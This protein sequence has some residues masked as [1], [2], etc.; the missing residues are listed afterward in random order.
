MLKAV[1][2]TF[3]SCRTY[4]VTVRYTRAKTR[5]PRLMTSKITPL[6]CAT[7]PSVS[8]QIRLCQKSRSR[9]FHSLLLPPRKPTFANVTS[10]THPHA[11]SVAGQVS[12][13]TTKRSYITDSGTN[14]F[15]CRSLHIQLDTHGYLGDGLEYLQG[16]MGA[17]CGMVKQS[18]LQAGTGS[19]TI[20]E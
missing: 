9:Y 17:I 6:I 2:A 18:F 7:T 13:F 1:V 20:N 15:Q 4:D 11:T 5:T 19:C 10:S 3:P 12:L 14:T 16:A 8:V